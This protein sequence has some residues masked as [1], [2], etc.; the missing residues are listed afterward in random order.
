MGQLPAERVPPDL[1]F[2]RIG[3]DYAGPLQLKLG[4]TWKQVI[5]KLIIRVHFCL[6]VSLCRAPGPHL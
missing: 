6:A 5:V 4:S 1:I 3:V 2:N